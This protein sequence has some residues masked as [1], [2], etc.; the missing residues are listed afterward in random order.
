MKVNIID[1]I[2]VSGESGFSY[3]INSSYCCL[4]SALKYGVRYEF[5]RGINQIVEEIDDGA[6]AIGCYMALNDCKKS[7]TVFEAPVFTSDGMLLTPRYLSQISCYM[8][9]SY[10]LFSSRRTV[11]EIVSQKIRK[12]HL[13]TS[14]E[15]VRTLFR[16]SKSRFDRRIEA[17]GHELFKAMASIA[18]CD[19]KEIYCFPWMSDY[20]FDSFKYHLKDLLDILNDLKKFV[21]LPVSKRQEW[22]SCAHWYE[23]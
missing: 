10:P 8:D 18:Y 3:K 9:L 2:S 13:N 21:I 17:T 14:K 16:M 15:E 22:E 20:Y 4:K 19:N 23:G 6:W 11:E 1:K 12:N 7:F 5:K